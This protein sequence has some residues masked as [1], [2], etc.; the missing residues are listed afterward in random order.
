MTPETLRR[1]RPGV[2]ILLFDPRGRAFVGQRNDTPGAW[3]MPQGGIDEAEDPRAAAM[4]ELAEETGVRAAEIVGETAGWVTYE[5][6]PELAARLWG[7]RYVGQR[8]K[9][10]AMRFLGKDA[11]IDLDAHEAEF[12][13]WRWVEIGDLVPLIVPFKRRLYEAV[14]AE[15]G[16]VVRANTGK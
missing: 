4:R 6:P 3:Q 2:G 11:E 10:F 16:P 9:W 15:L 7:G 1:Y 12:D 13:A 14:V 8:Q 5:Q